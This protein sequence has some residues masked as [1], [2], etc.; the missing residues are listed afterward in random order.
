M[1]NIRDFL[2]KFKD[3]TNHGLA[4]RTAVKNILKNDFS[5]NIPVESI[6]LKNKVLYL[7]TSGAEKMEVTIRQKEFIQKINR[8][9]G[10]EIVSR[11]V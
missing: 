4:F 2:G 8:H 5:V 1:R 9:F 7:K 11:V 6:K 10:R 3:T